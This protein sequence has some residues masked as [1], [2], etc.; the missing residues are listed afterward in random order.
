[1]F[2]PQSPQFHLG[3]K[4]YTK[5]T[6]L[7][8]QV[9]RLDEIKSENISWQHGVKSQEPRSQQTV[10]TGCVAQPHSIMK[11]IRTPVG[12][13]LFPLSSSRPINIMQFPAAAISPHLFQLL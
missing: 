1:M 5:Y 2:E 12:C 10:S 3:S 13:L 6:K 9:G 4:T 11:R 7:A 8:F